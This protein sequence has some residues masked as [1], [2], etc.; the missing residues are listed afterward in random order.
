[1]RRCSAVHWSGRRSDVDWSTTRHSAVMFPDVAEKAW[2]ASQLT[3]RRFVVLSLDVAVK[4]WLENRSTTRH[5]AVHR[6]T[7]VRM[8]GV[9]LAVAGLVW[10]QWLAF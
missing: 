8:V 10:G 1:M 9:E 4:A 6:A 2:L 5:F 7:V 3:M